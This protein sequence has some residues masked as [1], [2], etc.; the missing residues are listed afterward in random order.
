MLHSAAG[1][2][3]NGTF[4][5]DRTSRLT[6]YVLN[7]NILFNGKLRLPIQLTVNPIEI[8]AAAPVT[9]GGLGAG[10]N[11]AMVGLMRRNSADRIITNSSRSFIEQDRR[12]YA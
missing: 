1:A 4:D 10:P 11:R 7:S 5:E 9:I 12:N 8:P 2:S 3:L 6:K